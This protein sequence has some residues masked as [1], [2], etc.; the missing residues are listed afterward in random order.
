MPDALKAERRRRNQ[1]EKE[2]RSLKQQLNRFSEI[3]PE[4]HE[5]LQEA[6]KQRQKL[7]Q[8]LELRE[9]QME[10]AS[11]RKVPALAVRRDTGPSV[12]SSC[13]RK[14]AGAWLLKGSKSYRWRWPRPP[15][16][17]GTG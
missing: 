12:C 1:L 3:N 13:S 2:I 17:E 5:R 15:T 6:S 8:E 7:E 14:A 16:R 4:D 11:A 9:L 10:E